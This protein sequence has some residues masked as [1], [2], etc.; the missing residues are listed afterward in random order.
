MSASA[1]KVLRVMHSVPSVPKNDSKPQSP[2]GWAGLQGAL[3]SS[4]G[5]LCKSIHKKKHVEQRSYAEA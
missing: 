4:A 1:Q 5:V 3:T 2:A